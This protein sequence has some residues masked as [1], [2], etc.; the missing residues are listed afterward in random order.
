LGVQ[1]VAVVGIPDPE[2]GQKVAA[3]VVLEDG[4]V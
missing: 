2:W 4:K 3:A 1:D